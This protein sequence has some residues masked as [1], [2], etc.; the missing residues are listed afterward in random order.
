M[1]DIFAK[2]DTVKKYPFIV[3]YLEVDFEED[4]AL[5]AVFSVPKR[6]IKKATG[7][8]RIR[9]QIKEA[10]RLNK[11]DLIATLN[12]AGKGLALFFIYTGKEK[13]DYSVIEEKIKLLLKELKK[14]CHSNEEFGEEKK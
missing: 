3:K 10:Y 4:V 14:R 9:R 6:N 1:E 12:D 13:P 2:G 8:N 7:R 11:A 5:K